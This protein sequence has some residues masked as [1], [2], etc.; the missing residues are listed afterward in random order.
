MIAGHRLWK[1]TSQS[2]FQRHHLRDNTLLH[3]SWFHAIITVRWLLSQS[4][5]V[6]PEIELNVPSP[7]SLSNSDIWVLAPMYIMDKSWICMDKVGC[8]GYHGKILTHLWHPQDLS[9]KVVLTVLIQVYPK[10]IM[11]QISKLLS[12]CIWY[13]RVTYPSFMNFYPEFIQI[14]IQLNIQDLSKS[15]PFTYPKCIHSRTSIS[16]S[17]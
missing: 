8:H 15:Y 4:L 17:Q 7:I 11:T 10:S 13:P 3:Q 5:A 9:R 12:N 2:P 6:Q 14:H 16:F 1:Q